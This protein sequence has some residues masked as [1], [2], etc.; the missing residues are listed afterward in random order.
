[1]QARRL[2]LTSRDYALDAEKGLRWPSLDLGGD[3]YLK[4]PTAQKKI[5]WGVGLS[6]NLPLYSG[7]AIT[8]GIKAAEALSR[9]ARQTLSL[10]VRQAELDVKTAYDGLQTALSVAVSLDKA[11]ELAE[12]NAKAQ[13]ADYK[14]GLVT[15]LDA[16][17][18]LKTMQ[19]TALA[20]DHARIDTF[21]AQTRLEVAAGHD[22][23]E[24]K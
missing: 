14:L 9:S 2:D 5:H 4:R 21:W 18:S 8:A 13:M 24:I 20:L 17:T 23:M 6:A 7:G 15:N 16:L 22:I 11:R 1:M 12:A 19:D 10:A 3:Y